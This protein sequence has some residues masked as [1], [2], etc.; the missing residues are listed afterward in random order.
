MK[1][2]VAGS[3][4]RGNGY[5][6][7]GVSQTLLIEAGVNLNEIKELMGFDITSVVG[8]LVSHSHGDHFGKH[9]QYIEAGIDIFT[10]DQT[11]KS[12]HHRL[13]HVKDRQ[14]FTIGEFTVLP[15]KVVH[16]VQ[17]FA[18]LINHPESGD[19]LFCTDT[20]YVPYKFNSLN[21]IMIEANYSIEIA[22]QAIEN[23]AN[24]AVRDR[25][26][27]SH[28]EIS[29]LVE[30]LRQSDTGKLNNVVLLHLSSGNSDA[31]LFKNIIQEELPGK[32]VW[33]A[34]KG[35]N[36]NLDKTPF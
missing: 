25:V 2:I 8:C 26:L 13:H 27:N 12:P 28:M 22:N 21:N 18:Y 24:K 34:D 17:T 23:G 15:L 16:D 14:K 32:Q 19:I 35:L 10:G 1:L 31:R 20:H 36:I 4:S 5:I 7:R 6:L 11:I 29:T 3:S 33:I 9:R 30:F